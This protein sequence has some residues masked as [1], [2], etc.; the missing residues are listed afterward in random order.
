MYRSV[1]LK[2]LSEYHSLSICSRRLCFISLCV[3]FPGCVCVRVH[4]F[5]RIPVAVQ[6]KEHIFW[7]KTLLG[8]LNFWKLLSSA[9]VASRPAGASRP[10]SN[11]PSRRMNYA[12]HID[13]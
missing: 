3:L 4:M 13:S 11:P 10:I 6:R 2:L 5:L 8:G 7:L 9:A 1:L 12:S